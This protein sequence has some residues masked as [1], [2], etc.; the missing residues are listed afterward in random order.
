MKKITAVFF[1]VLIAFSGLPQGW[2]QVG[3]SDPAQIY[4]PNPGDLYPY[5][6]GVIWSLKFEP[7]Y[8]GNK[9]TRLYATG[10]S[11]GLW[12]SPGGKGN[13]WQLL[14]TDFLPETSVGDF[15]IDPNDR[16]KIIIGTGLPKIRQSRNKDLFAL[17]K[18][19]GI[20]KGKISGNGTVKWKLI[21]DQYFHEGDMLKDNAAFWHERT[22]CVGALQYAPDGRSIILAVIEELAV[23]KYRTCIYRS[24][25]GG[26]NWYLKIALDNLFLHELEPDPTNA[27]AMVLSCAFETNAPSHFYES[28]D[29]GN[30]WEAILTGNKTLDEEG[31]F[32][33]LC[34]D[35]DVPARLMIAK[36]SRYGNE[37]FLRSAD[38]ILPV[39][40]FRQWHN[41]GGCSA[42]DVS[43]YSND[44]YS[45][46][47]VNM[48]YGRS[49][50]TRGAGIW[51][52][53]TMEG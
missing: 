5:G 1:F 25:D 51:W 48:M 28:R 50:I 4:E 30:T 42:F 46:G 8:D 38:T 29:G 26:Y 33:K 7:R 18:G 35:N 36:I 49:H 23:L 31:C 3:I 15:A 37:V 41:A 39:Q 52:W 34:Y 32:F 10:L 19:R 14:N 6:I 24:D 44:W 12:L 27:G 45:I 2:K 11:S 47:S 22:K 17:P 16:N 43:S 53:E 21:P 40:R 9:R 13:D 20:F